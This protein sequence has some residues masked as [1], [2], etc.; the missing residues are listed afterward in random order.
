M[1]VVGLGLVAAAVAARVALGDR[2][3]PAA[4]VTWLRSTGEHGW[5]I[6]L[7]VLVF[8]V[9]STLFLPAVVLF[10]TGGLMWG[11]WPGA[12]IVWV[13]ANL[14]THVHFAFGR[15]VA[16][17]E[18]RRFLSA[19]PR[20]NWLT[21]ELEQGGVLTTI[22]VRQLPIP[23]PI[24]N[25][26][27]GASPMPFRRWLIGNAVGLA[28][29]CLLYTSVAA[30]LASGVEGAKQELATRVLITASLVIGFSLATRWVQR[31]MSASAAKKD[32]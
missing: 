25:L 10:V 30:A 19:R 15:W 7:F 13:A 4:L 26:A 8:F 21:R 28:P 16:G 1:V 9:A 18:V 17:D 20:V 23:F 24:T 5:A 12:L 6:P 22:M 2:F 27:G 29:N 14:A 3:E 11:W 31:R 32:A